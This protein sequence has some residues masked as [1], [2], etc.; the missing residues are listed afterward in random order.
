LDSRSTAV[1]NRA[2]TRSGDTLGHRLEQGPL[3]LGEALRYARDIAS[4]LRDLHEEG[5]AHGGISAHLVVL[6]ESGSL[7]I[8]PAGRHLSA[9]RIADVTAFGNLLYRMLASRKRTTEALSF[10]PR[11]RPPRKGP[12]AVQAA[13]VRLAE[14]CITAPPNNAPS[15]QK[16]ATELTLLTVQARQWE[17]GDSSLAPARAAGPDAPMAAPQERPARWEGL[18]QVDRHGRA[19]VVRQPQPG[20]FRAGRPDGDYLDGKCPRCLCS[21]VRLSRTR[22]GVERLL[23][24][25]GLPVRRCHRCYF[26]YIDLFKACLEMPTKKLNR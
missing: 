14:R 20:F 13:A 25:I 1:I 9:D 7:L 19:V 3:P 18:S 6:R 2:A 11:Q 4:H 23:R 24:T 10:T 16:V 26:R 5:R 22:N 12:G 8:S 15:M 21:K 17:T